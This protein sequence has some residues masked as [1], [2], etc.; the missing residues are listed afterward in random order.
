MIKVTKERWTW[1]YQ[2]G[3]LDWERCTQL[4]EKKKKQYDAI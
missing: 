2:Y 4:G 1:D 3:D